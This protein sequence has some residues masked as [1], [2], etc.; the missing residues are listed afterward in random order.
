MNIRRLIFL[1]F[2][3]CGPLPATAAAP[4]A[5]I[6]QQMSAWLA[7]NDGVGL[8]IGIYDDGQ[9]LFFN[10]G[11]PRQNAD[12][13]PTQDT[14]YEIGAIAKTMTGQLLARA[15]VEGRIEPEDDVAKYLGEPFPSLEF[16]GERLRIVHLA[17]MTSQ[18]ADN[19][20]D[21]SQVRPSGNEPVAVA[22]MRVLGQYSATEFLRQLRIV[23]PRRAPGGEL[24]QSNV[25]SMLLGVVLSRVYGEPFDVTLAR[26]IEKPL[27]MASGTQPNPKLLAKGYTKEGDELPTFG[28]R[29]AQTWGSLR[30][31]TDDLLK[32][33]AWQ[34]AE[35]DAS[36][37]LAHKPTWST[38]DGRQSVGFF[39]LMGESQHGRRLYHSGLTYGFASTCELYPD[40]K[41][42]VVLLANKATDGA[43]ESLRALSKQIVALLRPATPT[44]SAVSPPPA[45]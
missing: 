9:R 27:R 25:A 21:L 23:G 43:Q 6:R 38:T 28:A 39:W 44:S 32:F 31:S 45:R 20:P 34:L 40:A 12:K 29:M 11:V 26:E 19:I 42:A 1:C 2:V 33:A 30:Y 3:L 37:K 10:A 4:E 17:N 14:V 24:S 8:S 18:L 5:A 41:I 22:R 35:R 16:G 13:P 15:I 7:D 36:V